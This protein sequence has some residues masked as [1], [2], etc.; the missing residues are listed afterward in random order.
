MTLPAPRLDE[1]R[2]AAG[3]LRRSTDRQEQSIPDQQRSIERYA[4]EHCF[5]ILRWYIDDAI[6]GTS[7]VERK[8]FLKMIGDAEAPD[9]PFRYVL[10]YDVK[11]FGRLDNDEAGHYRFL[12]RQRGIEVVYTSEGFNGDDTDDLVRPVKQWQAR[13]E[14]REL[15]KVTIRGLLSRSGDGW[16]SGGQPPYGYDL[17]YSS[18]DGRFLMIVRYDYD[19]SKLILDEDGKVTR[20]VPRGESLALSKRD[21]CRLVPGA[22]ERV[23]VVRIIFHW[24][25]DLGWGF[26]RIADRLNQQAIP[27]PRSGKWSKQ[28]RDGWSMTTVRAILMNPVYVGDLVWNRRTSGKFHRIEKSRAV[29][30]KATAIGALDRNRPDDW[31]VVKDAHPALISRSLSQAANAKRE[32][33]RLDPSE[34]RYRTG[35]GARSPFLLSGLIRCQQCG[36]NWQGYTTNKGDK[37]NDGTSVKTLGYACGGYVTKGT[38]CCKRYVLPKDEAE[39]WVF[40]QITHIVKSYL[41]A[42][43]E[44]KLRRMIEQ[45][46]AAGERFDESELAQV[47]Q[48]RADIDATIDNLL[49]NITPTNREYVDRRIE[50]LNVENRDLEQREEALLEQQGRECQA[51]ELARAALLLARNVDRIAAHGTVEEKRVFIRAFLR[52]IEFDPQ[53]R[54][55]TAHFYAVPSLSDDL[56]PDAGDEPRY[57]PA[58]MDS[59]GK[60]SER[61]SDAKSSLRLRNLATRYTQKRTA[62]T[63][64]DS[65]LIMVAGAGFHGAQVTGSGRGERQIAISVP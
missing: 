21:R 13:Q 45:E 36:H 12:L 53:S 62:P 48:R 19:L 58:T 9:C 6:S 52:E 49:D 65:S 5:E 24:Y 47:R 31:V 59:A 40:E 64:G 39:Q 16:W 17:V 11:R 15:S 50:K 60:G 1:H 10:V 35:K 30:R 54:T 41:D 38:A 26:K 32:A 42:G 8:D 4:D 57:E 22:S 28:H 2:P 63:E 7:A 18:A 33:R 37:R 27:S 34:Y 23:R 46:V 44:D 55:G 3:Y 51:A 61:R 43:A 20:T 25:A 56:A 29:P 14:S